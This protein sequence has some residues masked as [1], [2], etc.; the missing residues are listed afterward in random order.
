MNEQRAA[1]VLGLGRVAA[2]TALLIAP[3][4]AVRIW[5]GRDATATERMAAR[6]LGGRD[7]ALGAGTLGALA[8]RTPVTPWLVAGA[9]ADASDALGALGGRRELS[10]VRRSALLASSCGA[11]VLGLRLARRS[12][13]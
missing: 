2:G 9:F 6:G 13:R 1:I 11:T 5:T 10:P 3:R 12:A 8:R 7:L 4:A